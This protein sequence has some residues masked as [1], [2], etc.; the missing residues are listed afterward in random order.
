MDRRFSPI[1]FAV[2]AI[3]VG[4][5]GVAL[6]QSFPTGFAQRC[7]PDALRIGPSPQD[8]CQPQFGQF[9]LKGPT[10]IGVRAL[11]VETTGA[12]PAERSDRKRP[13]GK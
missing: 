10:V 7:A 2:F 8:P 1:G 4:L 11:D 6:A 3:S 5:A 9:G 13:T 12:V